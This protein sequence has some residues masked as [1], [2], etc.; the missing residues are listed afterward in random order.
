MPIV[1]PNMGT[2]KLNAFALL[3]GTVDRTT[4]HNQYANDVPNKESDNSEAINGYD[5]SIAIMSS[6]HNAPTK[7]GTLPINICRPMTMRASTRPINRL[8]ATLLTETPTAAK[9]I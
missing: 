8:M 5:Q 9:P 1:N 6:V 3:R 2:R 7:S 4:H